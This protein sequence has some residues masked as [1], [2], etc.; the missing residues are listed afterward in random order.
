M[1]TV[2]K[3]E[4]WLPAVLQMVSVDIEEKTPNELS[5]SMDFY[6]GYNLQKTVSTRAFFNLNIRFVDNDPKKMEFLNHFIQAAQS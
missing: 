4:D 3:R 5:A 2:I 1:I 6:T